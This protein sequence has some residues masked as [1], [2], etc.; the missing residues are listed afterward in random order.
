MEALNQ[1]NKDVF[2]AIQDLM[3]NQVFL[4]AQL[5]FMNQHFAVFDENDENKLEY[6]GIYESYVQVME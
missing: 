4:N 3:T 1:T 2:K 5:T 6:T